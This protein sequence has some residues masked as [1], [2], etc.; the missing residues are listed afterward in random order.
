MER[1]ASGILAGLAATIVL[2]ALMVLK[3]MMGMMPDVDVIATL[4]RMMGAGAVMGWIAHVLI[5]AAYGLIFAAVF[6][7]TEVDRATGRGVLLAVLGWLVMMILVM[8]MTG[9]GLFGL[10]MRLG[11]TVPVATL[12]LH[13]IFGAVLGASHAGLRRRERETA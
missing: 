10:A 8:P 9:N 12:V 5:G 3:G 4:A 13:V 7:D 11:A 1:Y 6:D 2:S